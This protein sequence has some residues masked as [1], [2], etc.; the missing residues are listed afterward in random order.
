VKKAAG[1]D[2]KGEPVVDDDFKKNNCD[3]AIEA[4][5]EHERKHK[6]FYLSFPKIFEAGMDSRL[7]RLRSESE[8]ES[9]RAQKNFLE[10]KLAELKLKCLTTLDKSGKLLLQGEAVQR[11]RLNQAETRIRL[12]GTAHPGK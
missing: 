9:Y 11:E 4:E 1:L 7:L 5:K 10:K 12:L 6:E 2:E 3:D 8:V